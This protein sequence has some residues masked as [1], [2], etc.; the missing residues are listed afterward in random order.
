MS[1]DGAHKIFYGTRVSE[2]VAEM[3][4][5]RI[6]AKGT[7]PAAFLRYLIQKELNSQANKEFRRARITDQNWISSWDN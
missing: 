5:A 6:K 3:M 2:S 4:N 1:L 7:T